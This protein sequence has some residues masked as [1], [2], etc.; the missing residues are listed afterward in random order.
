MEQSSN[1]TQEWFRETWNRAAIRHRSG[2]ERHG[3]EQ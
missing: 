3:T 2:L 1:K